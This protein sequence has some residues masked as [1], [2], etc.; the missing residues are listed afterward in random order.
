MQENR[1]SQLYKEPPLLALCPRALWTG[2]SASEGGGGGGDAGR[3]GEGGGEESG[4]EDEM[5]E[6]QIKERRVEH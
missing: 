3:R 5:E 2:W 4:G 6:E 1:V